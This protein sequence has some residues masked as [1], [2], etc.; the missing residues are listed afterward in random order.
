MKNHESSAYL[1]N[2][3]FSKLFKFDSDSIIKNIFSILL[4]CEYV[5]IMKINANI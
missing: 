4:L 2:G 3:T 1:P 5:Y